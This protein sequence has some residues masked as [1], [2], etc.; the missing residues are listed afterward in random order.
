MHVNDP[1]GRSSPPLQGHS[2]PASPT[3]GGG[4][5]SAGSVRSY[6]ERSVH[7]TTHLA[8]Q[9]RRASTSP[10]S[11]PRL[12]TQA[13]EA[14]PASTPARCVRPSFGEALGARFVGAAPVQAVTAAVDL[15]CSLVAGAA[16]GRSLAGGAAQ[17]LISTGLRLTTDSAGHVATTGITRM[18]PIR[19]LTDK[20]RGEA[21]TKQETLSQIRAITA[22][23]NT[24]GGAATQIGHSAAAAAILR[25]ELLTAD[26]AAALVAGLASAGVISAGAM[27]LYQ[28][29]AAFRGEVNKHLKSLKDAAVRIL[30]QGGDSLPPSMRHADEMERGESPV[31]LRRTLPDLPAP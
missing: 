16:E 27:V 29:N 12:Q 14:A 6:S 24:G 20:I 18:P 25:Q 10:A 15:V 8:I 28:T 2:V 11:L 5:S 17:A 19:R 22:V 7:S 13:D 26:L 4:S 21:I 3:D 9:P 31:E 23:M 1:P 30:D